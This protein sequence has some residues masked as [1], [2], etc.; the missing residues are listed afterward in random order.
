MPTFGEFERRMLSYFTKGT[1]FFYN[2]RTMKVLES[3]KPTCSQGEPKTDIYVLASDGHNQEEIKI[4]YKKENADFLEN[5]TNAERA[6]QLFGPNWRVVIENSTTNIREQFEQRTRIYKEAFRRTEKGAIT[7]GWKFELLNKPAGDLSGKMDLSEQQV[8]D[9]Y[10]GTNL[11]RDK[12]DA[13]VNGRIVR[14]SGIAD[15][16][17][18]SDDVRSAQDAIDQMDSIWDYID[19]HPNIY[20]A[21]KALNYR[22]FRSKYD[23]NRPLAVQVDWRIQNDKL[24]SE[25]VFDSPLEMNGTEMAQRLL[26]CLNYLDIETTDDI[27]DDNADMQN[28]YE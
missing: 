14:N 1:E 10:A 15:Y 13:M 17:L 12:K 5:K 6:E 20:F 23:G 22:T 2:G 11:S 16:I 7:L 18:M 8:Y 24:C 3:D 26:R 4:S 19:K 25:L 21:C 28:V 9:V 27:D